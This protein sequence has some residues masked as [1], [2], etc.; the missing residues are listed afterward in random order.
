M[1]IASANIF[2]PVYPWK[3]QLKA[4]KKRIL[5]QIFCKKEDTPGD[6]NTPPERRCVCWENLAN[7][8]Q[9]LFG[10]GNPVA[11]VSGQVLTVGQGDVQGQFHFFFRIHLG[12]G[13]GS[14][15]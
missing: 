5:G 3:M 7:H 2:Y 4:R 11:T 10:A 15:G 9:N 1:E 13:E 14:A 6:K 8:R 12:Q